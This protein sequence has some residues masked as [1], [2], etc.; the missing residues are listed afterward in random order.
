M[1]STL[2]FSSMRQTSALR[3][4]RAEKTANVDFTLWK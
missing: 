4:Y 1:L 2:F 3:K